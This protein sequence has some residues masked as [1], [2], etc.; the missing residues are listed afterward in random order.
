LPRDRE[1]AW[2]GAATPA[3]FEE[4]RELSRALER[5]RADKADVGD[6]RSIALRLGPAGLWRLRLAQGSEL[7]SLDP[8]R[9]CARSALWSSATPIALDRHTKRQGAARLEEAAELTAESCIRLGLP[10]PARVRVH[11]HAAIAGA[12]SAWPPGG[13]PAWTGWAQPKTLAHR[14]LFHATIE[15]SEPVRGPVILGAGRF[16]GL[17][18]CLPV[19]AGEGT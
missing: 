2:R 9:Y 13:A 8:A 1:E 5:L 11:K 3:A 17:G 18:L 4:R 6:D 10:R 16:F 12:A 15:F 14:P 19:S 7:R